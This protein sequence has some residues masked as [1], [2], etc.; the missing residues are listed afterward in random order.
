MSHEEISFKEKIRS[1]QFAGKR[2]VPKTVIKDDKKHVELLGDKGQHGG[3][4]VH[5]KSGRQDAIANVETAVFDMKD[6]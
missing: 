2:T 1:L 4:E 6:L 5:H 3:W